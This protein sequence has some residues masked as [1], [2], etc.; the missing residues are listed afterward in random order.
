V[1]N[2]D[3]NHLGALVIIESKEIAAGAVNPQAIHATSQ[4]EID[5]AEKTLEIDF[6]ISLQGENHGRKDSPIAVCLHP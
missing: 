3:F 6:T 5:L 2:N 4:E 1:A